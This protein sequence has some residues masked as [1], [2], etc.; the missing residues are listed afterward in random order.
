[1]RPCNPLVELCCKYTTFFEKTT[2]RDRVNRQFL[3]SAPERNTMNAEK[4]T[5]IIVIGG[6]AA[7]LAAAVAAA[8]AGASVLV[9]EKMPRPGRKIMITGKGRCNFT[10]VKP[11][12]GFSRHIRSK[13]QFLRPA[14]F[15]FPPEQVIAFLREQGVET[16]VERGDRAFPASH[17]AS[18][19]VDALAGA[20]MRAGVRIETGSAAKRIFGDDEGFTVECYCRTFRSRLLILATGGLS[21]PGTGST[22]DGYAWAAQFGHTLRPCFP[23][24]TALVPKGYK[25]PGTGETTLPADYPSPKGHIDRSTELT[26]IGK[27]LC[28]N[29]I[30]NAGV[31]LYSGPDVLRD[32][33]G[34][35][36]FT[37]GGIEGPIG[38]AVSRDAV[39]ALLNGAKVRLR[40]DLKPGVAP[41][42]LL[43]RLKVLL[44]EILRDPRSKRL[45]IKEILRV[46]LGRVLPWE[47]IPG[48]LRCH[49]QMLA[50]RRGNERIDLG[51][52]ADALQAWDFDI[53]GFVGY[54][55]CVV[56][57]GGVATEEVFPKTM[58]SRL[59][60]GLYLCGELLDIDADTGGYNLQAAF[61]TGWLAGQS[62]ARSLKQAV[63]G[64]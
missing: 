25:L 3:I 29:A 54:E 11:W 64:A 28:G 15:N 55:R 23:S 47:L 48:F 21:Y 37:D 32:E 10:N 33:F 19:V 63:E 4:I 40:I 45:G 51:A 14:F 46:L 18:D 7:G 13:A 1:M 9:L 20:A 34:D 41:E 53:E 62:A 36:D 59:R 31:T 58:E 56:T 24:L 52:V 50:G 39:K 49:P 61:S 30:K 12:D 2:T 60:N 17:K 6:G 38:F 5:D 22:G 16:V 43:S 8:R 57:A 27:S 42:E 44:N 35:L 26:E